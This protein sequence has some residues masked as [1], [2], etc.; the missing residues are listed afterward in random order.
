MW[1][2]INKSVGQRA[3]TASSHLSV[4]AM[5]K[6]L[7]VQRLVARG[8]TEEEK[9]LR[10]DLPLKTKQNNGHWLGNHRGNV[11]TKS[12]RIYLLP[13]HSN[14]PENVSTSK[15]LSWTCLLCHHSIMCTCTPWGGWVLTIPLAQTDPEI[16]LTPAGMLAEARAPQGHR[17]QVSG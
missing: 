15:R 4:F 8:G 14:S 10:R 16:T 13:L 6:G 7:L 17:I 9:C 3:P 11:E 1:Q 2:S 5:G 12:R